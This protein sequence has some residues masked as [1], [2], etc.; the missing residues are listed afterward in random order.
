M[1]RIRAWVKSIEDIN[2]SLQERMFRLLTSVSLTVLLA[3]MV[4]CAL[5]GES[6]E[7]LIVLGLSWCAAFLITVVSARLNRVDIGIQMTGAV[8][9]YLILP[10]SFFYGGGINGGSASW[11]IF[12]FVYIC[13]MMSGRVRVAFMVTGVIV[14]G[15]CYLLA[16]THPE[17]VTGHADNMAYLDSFASIILLSAL[18]CVMF[19]FQRNAFEEQNRLAEE[20]KKEIM[21]L[22]ER[23]NHFFS[24]MSHEIR[25]PINTIIGLNEMTLREDISD[26]V[27]ENSL[28]I[29][30]ASRILLSLINDILD[31]SKIESGQMTIVDAPYDAGEMLSEIVN[32]IWSQAKEK[33]LAFHVD[34]D[35]S[36]PAAMIG[37]EVRIKQVL[38]NILNNAVKYTE[39]GSVSLSVQ[40]KKK[41]DKR[42]SVIYSVKDTGSGIRKESIPHL[43]SAFRRV[44]E[45]KNR[46]I[47]GTGL[48]LSIVKQLVELMDGEIT[49]DSIYTKG[50]TFVVILEQ[51]IENE[52]AI[53]NLNLAQHRSSERRRTY[54]K[55]FEAPKAR[56][57]IV[58]DNEVNLLVAK[59]LLRETGM[60]VDTVTSGE[61]CLQKSM[62]VHY[63]LVFMDHLMP[64]MDG[65]ECLHALRAQVGGLNTETPVVVL[66]ANAGSDAVAM[67]E[68]EGFDDC[69]LK[70]VSS[71]LLEQAALKFLPEELVNVT[72]EN[73]I[74]ETENLVRKGLRKRPVRI[75]TESVCDLPEKMIEKQAVSI[76]PC[77]VHTEGG[78][79]QDGVEIGANA[80]ITYIEELGKNAWASEP[81]VPDY[82]GFFARELEQAQNVIHIAGGKGASGAYPKAMAASQTFGNVT[83][84]NSAQ[85]SSGLGFL[86]LHASQMAE[87]GMPAR[88][89]V[90]NIEAMRARIRTTFLLDSTKYLKRNGRIPKRANIICEAF[91]LHPC[92]AMTEHGMQMQ[93]LYP[94]KRSTAWRHYISERLRDAARIDTSLLFIAYSGLS[95]RD[96]E[97]IEEQVNLRLPFERIIRQRVTPSSTTMFGP[98]T[99]GLIYAMK[100]R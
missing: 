89:I 79:F 93:K 15:G 85:M 35:P 66:T 98:G 72:V 64:E 62:F 33:G 37:D 30:G 80:A 7:V 36:L 41:D 87:Q 16:D 88:E 39:E 9:M 4:V 71:E 24:S 32:M 86:V 40:C 34:I 76:L 45:E 18:I 38:I 95:I 60:Q 96:I 26:E 58:D 91:M 21:E 23:Q 47:Q 50:S 20:Q 81:D 73:Q 1:E 5:V 59:K 49:V 53:G 6:A 78:V 27:A 19:L 52:T 83:V 74:L 57:L 3:V 56:V 77:L 90:K 10:V 22:N 54:V 70:P 31:M 67:Y 2:L 69:L 97:E 55:S 94:G 28:N 100:E 46:Y 65:V 75:T 13:L 61:E 84:I 29:Q 8:L 63:D 44:D 12:V 48:G 43:F 25:T 17:L 68:R 14:T 11:F 42:I 82:I 92:V 51:G 99:F